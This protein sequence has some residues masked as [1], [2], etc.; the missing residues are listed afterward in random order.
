VVT[1]AAVAP[2]A[3][4]GSGGD[5]DGGGKPAANAPW[6]IIE[7]HTPLI[8]SG[9]DVRA[10][11]LQEM[12]GLGADT[13]RLSVKWNEVAPGS[14]LTSKPSFDATNPKQ[15]PGFGAYDDVVRRATDRGMRLILVLAPDAPR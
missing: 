6:S 4:C 14:S 8:R 11:T 2:V 10:R 1:V 5:G 7:D 13:L 15:Y 12:R 9:E 3:G